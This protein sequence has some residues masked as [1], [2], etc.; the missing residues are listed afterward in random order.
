MKILTKR[1]TEQAVFRAAGRVPA[2]FLALCAFLTLPAEYSASSENLERARTSEKI[3]YANR[4]YFNYSLL[5]SRARTPSSALI[6]VKDILMRP[7]EVEGFALHPDL[8]E[9][10]YSENMRRVFLSLN[11]RPII[12]P[13]GTTGCHGAGIKIIFSSETRSGETTAG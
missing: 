4:E 11:C 12:R 10:M 7:A 2:L 13:T 8:L 3:T 1:R 6:E 5:L 9:R